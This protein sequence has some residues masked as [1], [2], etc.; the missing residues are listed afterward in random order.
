MNFIREFSGIM[1]YY[2]IKFSCLTPPIYYKLQ[3]AMCA[4]EYSVHTLTPD[5]HLMCEV[6]ATMNVYRAECSLSGAG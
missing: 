1:H 5:I 3:N 4:D 2:V 6:P